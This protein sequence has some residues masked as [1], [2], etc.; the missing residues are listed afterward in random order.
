MPAA[1]DGQTGSTLQRLE[2]S[3]TKPTGV[4]PALWQY[5]RPFAAARC[6]GHRSAVHRSSQRAALG[7]AARC[8]VL[9]SAVRLSHNLGAASTGLACLRMSGP[10]ACIHQMTDKSGL[11]S[12]SC[13]RAALV[14][15]TG[16]L[17]H[18]PES[19][20]CPSRAALVIGAKPTSIRLGSHLDI[21]SALLTRS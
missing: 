9:R 19:L 17:R 10:P 2:S 1:S 21:N 20:F 16:M 6:I 13:P 18:L 8:I 5:L 4:L 11:C 3:C 12:C 14:L 7:F 15:G